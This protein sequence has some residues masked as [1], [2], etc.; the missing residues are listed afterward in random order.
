[1]H[2][3]N[4]SDIEPLEEEPDRDCLNDDHDFKYAYSDGDIEIYKCR[5]CG[6]KYRD[7]AEK[8]DFE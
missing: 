3:S 1:M 2:N 8:E 7:A 6:K 4:Y 5:Y